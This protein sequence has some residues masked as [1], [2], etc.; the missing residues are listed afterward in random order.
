MIEIGS[1]GELVVVVGER[2]INIKV[3]LVK[4]HNQ[5]RHREGYA[6]KKVLYID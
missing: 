3:K 6:K 2:S 1:Y 4:S 5:L